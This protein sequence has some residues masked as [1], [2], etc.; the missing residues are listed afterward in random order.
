MKKI[1]LKTG[2]ELIIR[3]PSHDDAAAMLAFA[4]TVGDETE[5]LT[6]DSSD[7]KVTLSQEEELIRDHAARDNCLIILGFIDGVLVSMLS[8]KAS[9]RRKIKHYG[10]F[11]I[12]ILKDYWNNRIGYHMITHL[13]DW[14]RSTKIIRK[15]NLSV[16]EGNLGAYHLYRKLG[17]QIEGVESRAS[18]QEGGF[19]D[20][21]YMGL[22]ID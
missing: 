20:A 12:S 10:E 5:N 4:K 13:I 15:I 9:N 6:F 14:A 19:K 22:L 7:F 8:F 2:L 16:L 17:F 11:G 3:E 21:Y 18:F 1:L